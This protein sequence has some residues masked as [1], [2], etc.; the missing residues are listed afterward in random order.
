MSKIKPSS[1]PLQWTGN[2]FVDTGLAVMIAWAEAEGL[3]VF[4]PNNL[5]P[6]VLRQIVGDGSYLADANRRL[7][8]YSLVLGSNSPL[9]NSSTNPELVLSNLKLKVVAAKQKVGDI[10]AKIVEEQ[11]GKNRERE[12]I[13]TKKSA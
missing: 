3:E 12:F 5:T 4:T 2:P 6:D 9:M 7:K 11:G 13:A 1:Y 8:A 10:G